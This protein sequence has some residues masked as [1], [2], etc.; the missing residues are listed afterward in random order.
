MSTLEN[1]NKKFIKLNK[2]YVKL[3]SSWSEI[4]T[5]DAGILLSQKL[6]KIGDQMAIIATEIELLEK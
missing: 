3:D 5:E 4:V 2:S 1:L 6:E